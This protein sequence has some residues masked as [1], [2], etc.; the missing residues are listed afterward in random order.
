MRYTVVLLKI[1]Q[2]PSLCG[3]LMVGES[4][5]GK[6]MEI[7]LLS[8]PFCCTSKIALKKFKPVFKNVLGVWE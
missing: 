3:M 2:V 1:T 8:S 5:Y 6:Y 4:V 7:L